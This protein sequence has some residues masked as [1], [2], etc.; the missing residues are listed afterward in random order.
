M[1]EREQHGGSPFKAMK[2]LRVLNLEKS[3]RKAQGRAAA[4][5]LGEQPNFQATD[6]EGAEGQ[7]ASKIAAIQDSLQ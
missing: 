6:R 4:H 1:P 5:W 7:R 3:V 2:L